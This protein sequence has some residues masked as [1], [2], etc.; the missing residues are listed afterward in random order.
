LRL[1]DVDAVTARLGVLLEGP[2]ES[3]IERAV[4]ARMAPLLR[5]IE[6]LERAVAMRG[7]APVEHREARER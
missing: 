5:R 6:A 1:K 3:H 2:L 4:N 7:P